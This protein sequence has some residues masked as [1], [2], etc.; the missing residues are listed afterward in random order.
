MKPTIIEI[1]ISVIK[2]ILFFF[3]PVVWLVMGVAFVSLVDSYYGIKKVKKINREDPTKPKASSRGFREGYVPKVLGYTAV[4]LFTYFLDFHLLNEFTK[5]WVSIQFVS[6][7][8]IALVLIA[9]EVVSIDENWQ[10]LKGYSFLKKLQGLIIKIKD[11]KR[12]V[13]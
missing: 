1:F 8:I 9:N 7:K 4:L 12:D 3:T 10:E 2:G 6:T 11:I 13:E 5:Q